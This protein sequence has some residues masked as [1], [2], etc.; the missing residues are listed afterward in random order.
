MSNKLLTRSST[1]EIRR[2]KLDMSCCCGST[3]HCGTAMFRARRCMPSTWTTAKRCAFSLCITS[4]LPSSNNEMKLVHMEDVA[5]AKISH[6]EVKMSI[7]SSD[8]D[9]RSLALNCT[10]CNY[11][12]LAAYKSTTLGT[13]QAIHARVCLC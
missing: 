11:P 10:I 8:I 9:A 6:N 4:L 13:Y 2:N 12:S 7:S 5:L 3:W 1:M